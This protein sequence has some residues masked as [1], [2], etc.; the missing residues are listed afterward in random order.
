MKVSADFVGQLIGKGGE[1]IN[2][3]SRETGAGIEVS[4][5]DRAPERVVTLTGTAEA[6]DRAARMVEDV[7]GRARERGQ[8]R[9]ESGAS[10]AGEGERRKLIHVPQEYVGMLIGKGGEKIKAM[11]SG[12]G[13]R[14][15][16]SRDDGVADRTVTVTGKQDAIDKATFAIEDT[17]KRARELFAPAESDSESEPLPTPPPGFQECTHEGYLYNQAKNIFFEKTT[18]RICWLDA[19]SGAFHD[20]H[21][22]EIMNLTFLPAAATRLDSSS[23]GKPQLRTVAQQNPKHVVI[24]DLHRAALALRVDLDHLDRPAA[25]L[26]IFGAGT[27]E[28][29]V[30][31][32]IAARGLHE[33]LIRRLGSFRSSWPDEKLF[34]AITGALFDLAAGHR[35]VQPVAAVALVLG[36]RV[37]AVS[38]PG[39]NL[40]LFTGTGANSAVP[41]NSVVAGDASTCFEEVDVDGDPA[42]ATVCIALSSGDSSLDEGEMMMASAPHLYLGRPRAAS[43]ALLKAAKDRGAVG[44]LAAACAR[45]SLAGLFLGTAANGKSQSKPEDTPRKVRVSQILLRHWQGKGVQPVN[46]VR[47]K[48]VRRSAEDAEAQLLGVL[49]DLVENGTMNFRTVCKAVS[50]CQSA[51]KGGGLEGDLGWF[52]QEKDAA[53]KKAKGEPGNPK[54]VVR[55]VVP[56]PVLKVAFGLEVGELSDLIMSELG[57]HLL[58]RTA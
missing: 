14:I 48:P 2:A 4:K 13:A 28:D 39:T 18:G 20:H 45:L 51:L 9:V 35:G 38:A 5:D 22:G 41:S 25:M 3:V 10:V 52:D 6:V 26:G 1:T 42:A 7:V 31:V 57:A 19:V 34:E 21:V 23:G 27:S 8:S 53:L 50:D 33:K 12:T 24:P 54:S 47:R 37:A 55:A 44:P 30:P 56:A 46:P 16:V 11:Q 49:E 17:L 32:D 29:C 58:L 36:R 15:E 40:C 43:I